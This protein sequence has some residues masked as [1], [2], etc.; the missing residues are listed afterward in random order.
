MKT[1]PD[2]PSDIGPYKKPEAPKQKVPRRPIPGSR[3]AS[4]VLL[5]L[6]CAMA[7]IMALSPIFG[8]L[9]GIIVNLFVKW[10]EIGASIG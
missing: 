1:D 2:L 10:Y 3:F 9:T 6:I 4:R 5:P 8:L 7:F